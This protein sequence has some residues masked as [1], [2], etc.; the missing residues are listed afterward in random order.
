MAIRRLGIRGIRAP[1]NYCLPIHNLPPLQGVPVILARLQISCLLKKAHLCLPA[2][3][4]FIYSY[5][6]YS[7]IL[8]PYIIISSYSPSLRCRLPLSTFYYP[9]SLLLKARTG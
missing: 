6:L 8:L 1:P 4:P 2:L 5:T 3:T 7:I 9:L